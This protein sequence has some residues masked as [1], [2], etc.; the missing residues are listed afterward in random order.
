MKLIILAGLGLAFG[1]FINAL[2]W[3][4]RQN[5]RRSKS[6][7]S[8]L[9]GRSQCPKCHHELAA[10][11]LIPVLS[12]IFL[13]GRCRYCG[14]PISRQY[15]LVELATAV[16]FVGSY[17]FWPGGVYGAGDWLLLG[18]WLLSLVGLIALL[19]YDFRWMLLPNKILYP[20][21]LIAVSG[22][23]IYLVSFE[24]RIWHALAQWGLSVIVASGFFWLI[25]ILSEGR[26]IGYGDVRLGLITG[27][28]LADPAKSLLMIF[29]AS[30]LGLLAAMPGLL[31]GRKK[32]S[33]RLPYGPFLIMSTV[34]VL[35][36]GHHLID[37]Y[38]NN[39]LH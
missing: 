36:F 9:T 37:W 20:T 6:K 19:I 12:W 35:L 28:I 3:R 8:I 31:A 32:L 27:T 30:L 1:S 24:P 2:V 34:L 25:F 11:D 4:T 13:R 15:P 21:L 18:T 14:A 17:F 39:L 5:E 26:L 38:K 33:S 7:F 16:V 22:R 10:R 29:T 23:V